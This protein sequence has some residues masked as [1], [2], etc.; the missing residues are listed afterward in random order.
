MA[1]EIMHIDTNRVEGVLDG[2]LP[3]ALERE[4]T[5]L[6]ARINSWSRRIAD[7]SITTI[8]EMRLTAYEALARYREDLARA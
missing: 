3:F 2:V 7:R 1:L 6:I 8:A 4:G 5:N